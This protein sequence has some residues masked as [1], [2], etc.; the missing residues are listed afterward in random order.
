[1]LDWHWT[2]VTNISLFVLTKKRLLHF[3]IKE[4]HLAKKSSNKTIIDRGGPRRFPFARILDFSSSPHGKDLGPKSTILHNVVYIMVQKA[5]NCIKYENVNV[6]NFLLYNAK[7]HYIYMYICIYLSVMWFIP[8]YLHSY[9][10]Q[11]HTMI[12]N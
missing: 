1:M 12:S 9:I 4:K 3:T 11:V 8:E 6:L 5:R 2:H 10:Y 7:L